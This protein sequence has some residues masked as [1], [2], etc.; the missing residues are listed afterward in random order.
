MFVEDADAREWSKDE[1]IRRLLGD[2]FDLELQ[3]GEWRVEEESGDDLWELVST[4]M[5]P[6]RA[7]LAEQSDEVRARAERVYL[8]YLA[9]GVL[10]RNYVLVLGT[11]R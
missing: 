4:S 10:A 6:L 8:D 7:W 9:S 2:A 11:R 5:P 3:S 1:H